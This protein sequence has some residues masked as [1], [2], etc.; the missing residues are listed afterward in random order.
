MTPTY[1]D[2][3][4]EDGQQFKDDA[5]LVVMF[6]PRPIKMEAASIEAG[7]PIF[8][9]FDYIKIITP[10]SRD[11]LDTEV[12]DQYRRRFS[13]QYAN[14]KARIAQ[15]DVGTPLV[16]EFKGVNIKTVEQLVSLPDVLAQK[17]PGIN[18]IMRR[19]QR[20]LDAAADAAPDLKL[21]A[22][23]KERDE[24]IAE[25]NRKVA[26]LLQSKDVPAAQEAK[27]VPP[28]QLKK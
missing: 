4:Y 20:F 18:D 5:K 12:T 19:A 8:Q 25:L 17:F 23:L 9:D 15:T 11:T 22:A 21:E 24:Q 28:S 1:E 27:L 7:R 14:Y 3:V 6:Y 26:L 2:Q 16:M 10:G 13:V